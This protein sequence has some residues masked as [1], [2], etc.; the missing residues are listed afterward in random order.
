MIGFMK[1][2]DPVVNIL[3]KYWLKILNTLNI[4]H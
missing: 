2:F 4:T 1:I 3:K